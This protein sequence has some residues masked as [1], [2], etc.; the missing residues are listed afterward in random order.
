[1]IR[2]KGCRKDRHLSGKRAQICICR[3]ISHWSRKISLK[4]TRQI[5]QDDINL[6]PKKNNC[7]QVSSRSSN[8]QPLFVNEYEFKVGWQSSS[9][10]NK[11][12]RHRLSTST[13]LF[14]TTFTRTIKLN[15]LFIWLLGSNLSQKK[16]K[17][18]IRFRRA[19]HQ[20][21]CSKT[22]PYAT[23]RFFS[24]L[25][26]WIPDFDCTLQF[27]LA[28]ILKSRFWRSKILNSRFWNAKILN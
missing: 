14:R 13:V 9:L 6:L 18:L 27:W 19:K 21:L 12:L 20:H 17:Q 22:K 5:T 8:D 4:I 10:K 11:W 24:I 7:C 1:M 28:K 2:W 3:K 26:S 15:L 25:K 16:K 23:L